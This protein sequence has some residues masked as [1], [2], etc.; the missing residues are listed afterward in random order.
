MIDKDLFA[1]AIGVIKN[2][3]ST[4]INQLCEDMGLYYETAEDVLNQLTQC[5]LV[6][7]FGYFYAPVDLAEFN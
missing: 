5:Q 6:A 3:P 4:T 7:D 1:R 2:N